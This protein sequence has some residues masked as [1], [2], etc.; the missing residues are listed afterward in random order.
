MDQNIVKSSIPV[1]QVLPG[2]SDASGVL[3][4]VPRSRCLL[5]LGMVLGWV[6]WFIAGSSLAAADVSPTNDYSAVDAIFSKHCLECHEAK[7][8]EANLVLEGF[9]GLMKGSEN[10]AVIVPGKSAE[11]LLVRMIEGVEK[12]GKK[13]IMPPGKRKKLEPEEIALIKG[14]I[15]AG[16]KPPAENKIR[17][18]VVPKIQPKVPARKAIQI[19]RASCR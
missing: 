10:G 1:R 9:E 5:V 13:K 16:A 8:P 3:L 7:D 19:G 12:D 15:D 2:R 4:C 6:S 17:E 14:W 11:S 18:L